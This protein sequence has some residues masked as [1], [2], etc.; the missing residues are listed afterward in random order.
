MYSLGVRHMSLRSSQAV[1][2]A[3]EEGN[4][5]LDLVFIHFNL[6]SHMETGGYHIGEPRKS[7]AQRREDF[8]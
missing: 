3:A 8:A 5:P 4:C 2:S 7:S 1:A 6:S